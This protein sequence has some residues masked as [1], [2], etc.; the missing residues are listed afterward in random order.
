LPRIDYSEWFRD[1]PGPG[2]P[3]PRSRGARCLNNVAVDDQGCVAIEEGDD[4]YEEHAGD[5]HVDPSDDFHLFPDTRDHRVVPIHPKHRHFPERREGV[6]AHRLTDEEIAAA[7]ERA[8]MIAITDLSQYA[9]DT[10][11]DVEGLEGSGG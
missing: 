4:G 1:H 10:V 3:D 2:I 9:A 7:I 8:H 5:I 6:P 11:I